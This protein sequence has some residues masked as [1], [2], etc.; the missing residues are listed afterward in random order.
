[1]TGIITSVVV[2]VDV[3]QK[4]FS[5]NINGVDCVLETETQAYTYQIRNGEATLK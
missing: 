1:M 5:N 4:I 3:M 2:W